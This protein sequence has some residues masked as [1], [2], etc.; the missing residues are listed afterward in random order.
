M[1]VVYDCI[2]G[3]GKY[4]YFET[5][6]PVQSGDQ[7][8]YE[9]DTIKAYTPTKC[10]KFAYHMYGANMGQLRLLGKAGRRETQLFRDNKSENRWKEFEVT[11]P[12]LD[13]DYKVSG[14]F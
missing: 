14:I 7:A 9:S 3:Y 8:V 12:E 11:L 2:V 10:L 4:L 6:I 1:S 5:S 13:R